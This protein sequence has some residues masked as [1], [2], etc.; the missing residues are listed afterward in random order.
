M[1]TF[2]ASGGESPFSIVFDPDDQ[3][4]FTANDASNS[5]S[6]ID[7]PSISKICQDSGFDTGDIRTF[8]F[9]GEV[10]QQTTCVN[11][12]EQC[13]GNIDE[14]AIDE[15]QQCIIDDYVVSANVLE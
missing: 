9:E 1:L 2:L 4:V 7:I 8:G 6:I 5:V 3:R 10:L 15:T 12:S 13:I 14:N 11:F